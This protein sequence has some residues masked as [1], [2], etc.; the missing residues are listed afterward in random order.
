ML[1]SCCRLWGTRIKIGYKNCL[2]VNEVYAFFDEFVL[3]PNRRQEQKKYIK[4]AIECDFYGSVI[5]RT[6]RKIQI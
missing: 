3:Q 4:S 1:V 6:E 2:A 5:T